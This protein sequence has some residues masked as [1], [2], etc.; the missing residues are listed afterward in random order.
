LYSV[1]KYLLENNKI[2]YSQ[3]FYVNKEWS[4]FDEIKDYD[5][6]NELFNSFEKLN[7]EKTFF[8]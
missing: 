6:L 3:I 8:I 2:D 4:E 7:K 5:D 1:L